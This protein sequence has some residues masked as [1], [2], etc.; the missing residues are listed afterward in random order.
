M[1]AIGQVNLLLCGSTRAKTTLNPLFKAFNMRD[2]LKIV[3][4]HVQMPCF[5]QHMLSVTYVFQHR[6][7]ILLFLYNWFFDTEGLSFFS[8]LLLFN[9]IYSKFPELLLE[10]QL[11]VLVSYVVFNLLLAALELKHDLFV[12]HLNSLVIITLSCLQVLKC[13]VTSSTS[14]KIDLFLLFVVLSK[15]SSFFGLIFLSLINSFFH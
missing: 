3:L 8:D 12:A 9:I 2:L 15:P 7:V 14:I 1:R 5:N 13:F 6:F 4:H 11:V 10:H